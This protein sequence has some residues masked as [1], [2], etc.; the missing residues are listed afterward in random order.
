MS[1]DPSR[2]VAVNRRRCLPAPSGKAG[3]NVNYLYEFSAGMCFVSGAA[4]AAL[5]RRW[6]AKSV[7]LAVLAVQAMMLFGSTGQAL[8]PGTAGHDGLRENSALLMSEI[9]N[10]EGPVLADTFMGL[11]PLSGRR[12]VLQPFEMKQLSESGI[13]DETPLLEDIRKKKF[14][15]ILLYAPSEDTLS[16]VW[17]GSQLQAVRANYRLAGKRGNVLIYRPRM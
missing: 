12:L 5:G 10:T 7:L 16:G 1:V 3:S 14:G 15:L 13:W 17:T 11:L 4:I 8:S 6:R 9:R 2:H